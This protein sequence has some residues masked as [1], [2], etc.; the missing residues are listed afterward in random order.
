LVTES[1]NFIQIKKQVIRFF[2][3]PYLLPLPE[4]AA[5]RLALSVKAAARHLSIDCVKDT[6]ASTPRFRRVR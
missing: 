4:N 1:L 2:K 5:Q 6:G 3:N